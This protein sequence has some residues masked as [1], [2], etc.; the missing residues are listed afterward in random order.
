MSETKVMETIGS[1]KS[2]K[3]S[4]IVEAS[5]LSPKDVNQALRKLRASQKVR[6]VGHSYM[7]TVLSTPDEVSVLR[8]I[9]KLT[10]QSEEVTRSKLI[11]LT[12][13]SS[14]MVNDCLRNLTLAKI[15]RRKDGEL[16]LTT[17]ADVSLTTVEDR[18][19]QILCTGGTFSL[20]ALAREAGV[21]PRLGV[22]I[23]NK[24]LM[25]EYVKKIG[26][27]YRAA[28]FEGLGGV[29][30]KVTTTQ[31]RSSLTADTLL[32]AIKDSPGITLDELAQSL[33]V[34]PERIN[35]AIRVSEGNGLLC[36][37][38]DGSMKLTEVG[39]AVA[40]L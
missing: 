34:G 6:R 14:T 17:P 30:R 3:T 1:R 24:Y 26:S 21:S 28:S 22:K 4:E 31:I 29:C 19:A 13:A 2:M 9:R 23:L 15:L 5:G 39:I 16:H 38:E 35:D 37:S 12:G 7:S 11:S 20:D 25:V 10:Q 18:M 33:S 36:V 32:N 40:D 8:Q 27:R